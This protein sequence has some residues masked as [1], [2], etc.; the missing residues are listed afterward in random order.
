MNRHALSRRLSV[1]LSLVLLTMV[2]TPVDAQKT[3]LP[4]TATAVKREPRWW[5]GQLRQAREL[6]QKA[7]VAFQNA[8]TDEGSPIDE[9]AHQAA[10]DYYVLIRSARYGIDGSLHEDKFHDP[11]LEV[12]ARKVNEAWQLSRSPVD[13]A[14][15][16]M[17][18]QEYLELAVRDLRQSVRLLD[19]VLILLP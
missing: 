13:K 4:A 19:Q 5:T 3:T 10:R 18:R 14:S 2:A 1:L 16:S 11:L 17:S 7:L 15:S 9:A 6:G 8:P 12:T